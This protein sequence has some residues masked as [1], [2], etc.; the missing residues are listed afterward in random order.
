MHSAFCKKPNV[1]VASHSIPA[2]SDGVDGRV[3]A[4]VLHLD[5]WGGPGWRLRPR[6][7]EPGLLPDP[8]RQ[9]PDPLLPVL[10]DRVD[11]GI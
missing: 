2:S 1:V 3:L 4:D 6:R 7:P 10:D 9:L 8:L 11:A 5:P